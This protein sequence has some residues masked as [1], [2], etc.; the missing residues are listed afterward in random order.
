MVEQSPQPDVLRVINEAD[1]ELSKAHQILI[2][3]EKR[4]K[5]TER[6]RID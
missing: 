3:R 4:N 2:E 1:Y 6:E 5:S